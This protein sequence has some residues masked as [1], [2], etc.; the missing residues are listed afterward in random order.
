[1]SFSDIVIPR[2]EVLR[3]DGIEGVIDI[4]NRRDQKRKAIESRPD[5]FF[6]LT[7]PTSDIRQVIEHLNR[8]FNTSEKTPGL[9]LL[10]G[11]KGTGKSHLELLVY[12]LFA[13]YTSASK[14]LSKHGL[15]CNIPTDAKVLIHKFTDFP[16]DSIWALVFTELGLGK[17]V[18]YDGVPNLDELRNALGNRKLVLILDELELGITMI[19]NEHIRSQNI[20]FLQMLSEESVR[21]EN[22]SVTMFASVYDSRKEPGA[23]L[24]RVPRIDIKFSDPQDRQRVVLHRLFT[25]YLQIDRSRVESVIQSF[26][27]TWKRH[28]ISV[29]EKYIDRFVNTYPFTPELM[30][31][32]LFRVPSRGGFQGSRGALGLLGTVIR[33]TYRKTDFV[34]TAHLNLEDVGIVNRLSDLDPSRQIL[35]CAAN[36]LRDLRDLPFAGEIVAST[37]IATLAPAGHLTGISDQELARQ[38]IK[39]GDDINEYNG[40]LQAFEK[41]GTY[42]QKA[43]GNYFFDAQEKPNAKVEYRSLRVDP[44]R[45]LD[46]ALEQWKTKLFNGDKAVVFRGDTSQTKAALSGFEANSLRFVL[47]PQRLSPDERAE[48]YRGVENRN[49]VILL[50]PKSD[51]FN[52]LDNPDIIKWAQ[53]ALA[54]DELQ[55]TASDSERRRQYEKI[56]LADVGYILDYFRKAG[57][58]FVWIQ[59]NGGSKG[60]FSA[61]LEPLGN[62]VTRDDVLRQLRENI[63]PRQR[64]E[65]HLAS[66]RSEIV[67][68]TVR[69]VDAE[70]RKTLGFP[71]RTADNTLLDSIKTLCQS[72]QIGL[73][74]ERDSACGRLP[75]LSSTE[76]FDARIVE[77]FE[78]A[79][80]GGSFFP[81]ARPIEVSKKQPEVAQISTS[82]KAPSDTGAIGLPATLESVQTPF[83]TTLGALRQEVAMKLSELQDAKIRRIQ[84][85]VFGEQANTDLSTLPA[86][87]RGSLTGPADVTIDLSI[88]KQGEYS[89][90]H[91]EQMTEMLPSFPGAQYRAEL[92]VEVTKKEVASEQS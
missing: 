27:N 91:V 77:P 13:N 54:A 43:E 87:L 40:T 23:T 46:F 31:M 12:H 82:M 5:D 2:Q 85:F 62:A 71:V 6:D 55:K 76:L 37:L 16:V 14:W 35:D 29:D 84:F 28:K 79:K 81:S 3:K 86:S 59:P 72:R 63:F 78:D 44:T 68:K 11:Y 42:F 21:T 64:F 1:M 53:R 74:H 7:F 38:V 18:S 52:A 33:N 58:L 67:N 24:K 19:G 45:A 22:A 25:N 69:E 36:D 34:S 50:E 20:A 61:E 4:E 26:V 8:R 9:F 65:E 80:V 39:P 70:Y 51:T 17:S 48:I 88:N 32:V 49:Q 73:R 83:V 66:R 47:A 89:K 10:E 41:L 56:A 57:L 92:K 75:D 60:E 90:A 30:D 15:K